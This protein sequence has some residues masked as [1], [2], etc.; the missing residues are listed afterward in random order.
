MQA[1]V[2][3]ATGTRLGQPLAAGMELK[4]ANDESLKA[5]DVSSGFCLGAPRAHWNKC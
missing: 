5:E 2:P 1:A 4:A 3:L